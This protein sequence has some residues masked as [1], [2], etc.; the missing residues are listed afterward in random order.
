[1]TNG[2][3]R[4][5]TTCSAVCLAPYL[6]PPLL[7][8][9]A[10]ANVSCVQELRKA[11]GQQLREVQVVQGEAVKQLQDEQYQA[12]RKE[13]QL[14]VRDGAVRLTFLLSNSSS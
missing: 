9:A 10:P 4:M 12:K 2:I 6:N 11:S 13:A 5:A 8:C 14:K 7:C 1:M 3:Y